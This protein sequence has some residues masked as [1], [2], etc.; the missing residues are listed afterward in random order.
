MNAGDVYFAEVPFKNRHG[1]KVRPVV[2]VKILTDDEVFV[3]ESRGKEHANLDLLG[4][5]DFDRREYRNRAIA[6]KSFFYTANV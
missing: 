2:I 4:I 1:S 3:V 6:G 5:I